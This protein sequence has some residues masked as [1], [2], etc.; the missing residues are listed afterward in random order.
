MNISLRTPKTQKPTGALA[1][2]PLGT[3]D[4]GVFG[5]VDSRG[6]VTGFGHRLGFWVGTGERWFRNRQEALLRQ[7]WETDTPVLTTRVRFADGEVAVRTC[8]ARAAEPGGGRDAII[9]EC[10]NDAAVAVVFAIEIDGFA[11]M[12]QATGNGLQ[13]GTQADLF[14]SRPPAQ[15]ASAA[16]GELSPEQAQNFTVTS[17]E[18]VT[19]GTD[20]QSPATVW[21]FTLPHKATLTL[22]LIGHGTQGHTPRCPPLPAPDMVARGWTKHLEN[23]A[24][25]DTPFELL[26]HVTTR[27]KAVA[28]LGAADIEHRIGTDP[29][30][31]L[32]AELTAAGAW[33]LPVALS[34]V[35]AEIVANLQRK[36]RY[37]TD[38]DRS[39]LLPVAVG[40]WLGRG[41]RRDALGEMV[42]PLEAVGWWL[43]RKGFKPAVEIL[44]APGVA[45]NVDWTFQ[46]LV[47]ALRAHGLVELADLYTQLGDAFRERSATGMQPVSRVASSPDANDVVD[48]VEQCASLFHHVGSGSGSAAS[49]NDQKQVIENNDRDLF[50]LRELV[51]QTGI[52]GVFPR[53]VQN[54]RVP[55]GAPWDREAVAAYLLAIRHIAVNENGTMVEMWPGFGFTFLGHA[56]DAKNV[57]S[58]GGALS[59]SLRWHD[60]NPLLMWEVAA[61]AAVTALQCSTI[62]RSWSAG[63]SL[64]GEDTMTGDV[65]LAPPKGAQDFRVGES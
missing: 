34:D 37:R 25:I 23:T 13:L 14:W 26:N 46:Q 22:S 31:S 20:T 27:A 55:Q 56:L 43:A 8:G 60:E 40:A 7:E 16:E 58:N 2:A 28:L 39:L 45:A 49:E 51:H 19:L 52:T 18:G 47:V 6:T 38:G 54:R 65:L 44:Q 64:T 30:P 5:E 41:G 33:R 59:S 24:T 57:P 4:G 42:S 63:Q 53:V 35:I 3:L 21:F 32:I 12:L 62:D 50:A 10:V 29:V 9:M 15:F 17:V 11:G 1:A 36:G 61:P 48:V